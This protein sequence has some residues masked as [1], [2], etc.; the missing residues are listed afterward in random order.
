M[1]CACESLTFDR[2]HHL[3]QQFKACWSKCP[4]LNQ[5][6]IPDWASFEVA[7]RSLTETGATHRS[8]PL[9]AFERGYLPRLTGV[10]H[11]Y[12]MDGDAVK[13]S[14][15]K[16]YRRALR[17]RW[18]RCDDPLERHRHSRSYLGKPVELLVA[19]DLEGAG[20]AIV[21]L[22][23]TGQ[24]SDIVA[25]RNGDILFAEVKFI[26]TE[27]GTFSAIENDLTTGGVS[28]FFRDPDVAHDYLLTRLFEAAK[29]LEGK[30]GR[31]MAIAVIDDVTS[32][33]I[34]KFVLER[35]FFDWNAPRFLSSN[36]KMKDHLDELRCK[37]PSLDQEIGHLLEIVNEV[38]I[39]RLGGGYELELHSAIPKG[40]I[41]T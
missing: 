40:T 12:L 41:I 7:D 1:T 33:S 36:T 27:D 23:A 3:L 11:K 24:E 28:V 6:L 22:E 18:H 2:D 10:I 17:E 9:L 16:D 31:R 35:G 38:R 13:T 20:M 30:D 14:V 15:T 32:W 37:Y 25:S 21:G 8:M 19:Q 39:Y 29:Q 4:A 5:L 34:F 26:G